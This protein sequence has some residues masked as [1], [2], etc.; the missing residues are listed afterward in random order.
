MF[1]L[2]WKRCVFH[3][4]HC[5]Q[6]KRFKVSGKK[7]ASF[8]FMQRSWYVYFPSAL[9]MEESVHIISFAM[10]FKP[11]LYVYNLLFLKL[12]NIF[13]VFNWSFRSVSSNGKWRSTE[14]DCSHHSKI[15]KFVSDLHF[16]QEEIRLIPICSPLF[17]FSMLSFIIPLSTAS[18]WDLLCAEI[19]YPKTR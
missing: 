16:L 2:W 4:Y 8:A 3:Q 10:R 13:S 1:P 6:M 14:I 11:F 12:W 9:T 18:Q 7:S 5:V 17:C 19:F 15:W